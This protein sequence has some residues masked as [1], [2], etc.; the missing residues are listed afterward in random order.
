[1]AIVESKCLHGMGNESL[2]LL[3]YYAMGKGLFLPFVLKSQER[4][5]VLS[6][7]VKGPGLL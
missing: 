1:M 4:W 5:T 6:S 3:K 7:A 2:S